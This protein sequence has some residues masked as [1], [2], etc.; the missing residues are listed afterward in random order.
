MGFK[1][2]WDLFDTNKILS[3]NSLITFPNMHSISTFFQCFQWKQVKVKYI[4][5]EPEGFHL[6]V[7]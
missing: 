1:V 4:W 3:V 6:V 2:V 5:M 7:I